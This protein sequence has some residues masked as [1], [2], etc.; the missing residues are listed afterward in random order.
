MDSVVSHKAQTLLQRGACVGFGAVIQQELRE[1]SASLPATTIGLR[2]HAS[3]QSR[4]A[5]EALAIDLGLRVYI[6][7]ALDQPARD[8]DLIEVRADVQ[9]RGTG[10][11]RAVQRERPI[12]TASEL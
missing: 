6:C 12:G 10:E 7:A 4:V 9:Q 8:I 1:S 3:E 5:A 11:R 2:H